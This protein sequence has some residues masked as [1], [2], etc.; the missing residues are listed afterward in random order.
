MTDPVYTSDIFTYDIFTYGIF[1]TLALTFLPM[2]IL[3]L[4]LLP[5]AILPL[6]FLPHTERT[7]AATMA[8]H[9]IGKGKG[10]KRQ[11]RY[12]NFQIRQRQLY[13]EYSGDERD[14][15]NFLNVVGHSIGLET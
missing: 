8:Q 14:I 15:A 7:A 5:M 2:A 6:A 1:T 12:V 9:E 10:K 3:P 11:R 13:V 4:T